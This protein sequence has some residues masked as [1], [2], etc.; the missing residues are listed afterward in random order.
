[1]CFLIHLSLNTLDLHFLLVQFCLDY[2]SY[3]PIRILPVLPGNVSDLPLCVSQVGL[4]N[5]QPLDL[6]DT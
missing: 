4:S 3:L 5:K 2:F 1:M 6:C